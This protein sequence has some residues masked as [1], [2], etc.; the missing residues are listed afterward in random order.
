MQ[1]LYGDFHELFD[2][3]GVLKQD[4]WLKDGKIYFTEE[5][6]PQQSDV[7]IAAPYFYLAAFE[8]LSCSFVHHEMDLISVFQCEGQ[9][10]AVILFCDF[11]KNLL[12]H[13]TCHQLG[14]QVMIP[15]TGTS[16]KVE[17]HPVD[18]G[19]LLP[20][21]NRIS[22]L[23]GAAV[24]ALLDKLESPKG[25]SMKIKWNSS[26]L[27]EG[28]I[29]PQT[30]LQSILALLKIGFLPACGGSE[31]RL[32]IQ[33]KTLYNIAIGDIAKQFQNGSIVA[34]VG[35]ELIG[36]AGTKD[37]QHVAARNAIAATFLEQ[38]YQLEWVSK[39]TDVILQKL[40]IKRAMQAAQFPPGKQKLD[41]LLA[42]CNE[43]QV[44]I[45][46]KATQD[47]AKVVQVTPQSKQRKA[48]PV[49]PNPSHYS[50]EPGFLT[51]DAGELLPQL[52]DVRA[53]LSGFVLM[54]EEQAKPWIREGQVITKD[55]LA[56]LII[57]QQSI[58]TSLQH[59]SVNVPC[60]DPNQR[61]VVLSC[62][63]VQL[64]EKK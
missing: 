45:P 58:Q 53:Q 43:A 49:Q 36:G 63:L 47:A 8:L 23:T 15:T 27:W 10:T 18:G 16:G 62:M 61:P 51:T 38:G 14:S 9:T 31:V 3:F 12:S 2:E 21:T 48:M 55:E 52:P 6:Q 56:I 30:N 19:T 37:S 41:T 25:I 57:G 13:E 32:V 50:I 33:G 11:W 20:L 35:F 59:E 1:Q 60:K 17:F 46:K 44:E 26:L 64:G 40:G 54:S 7:T 39:T 42:M 29:D 4:D 5:I 22:C 28:Q 34:H 24:R